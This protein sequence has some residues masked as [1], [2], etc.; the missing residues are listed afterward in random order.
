[1]TRK[2]KFNLSLIIIT[3]LVIAFDQYMKATWDHSVVANEYQRY[4][5]YYKDG[6]RK[7]LD[8]KELDAIPAKY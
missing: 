5:I 2:R 8:S 7:T 6:N 1:M 4:I 3:L